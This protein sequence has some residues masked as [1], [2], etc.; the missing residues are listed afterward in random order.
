MDV[1]PSSI[2]DG[3]S[4]K[5][6]RS[7][8]NSISSSSSLPRLHPPSPFFFADIHVHIHVYRGVCMCD[9]VLIDMIVTSFAVFVQK[10][11]CMSQKAKRGV[12]VMWC[13]CGGG[14]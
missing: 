10:Y 13:G 4:S 2:P 11:L 7:G 3:R 8:Y 12:D 6:T 1:Y 9:P 14:Y 5:G